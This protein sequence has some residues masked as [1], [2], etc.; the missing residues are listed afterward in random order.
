M[1][2]RRGC[3]CGCGGLLVVMIALVAAG[4]FFVYRPIINFVDGWRVPARSAQLPRPS[5]NLNAPISRSEVEQF[6]RVRR[7][8]RK[9]LGGSFSSAQSIL[10]DIQNGQT[11]SFWQFAGAMRDLGTSVGAA[12]QAQV[13]GLIGQNLSR[14][15]YNVIA[16]GV[17]RSLGVP[18][19]DF[20]KIASDIKSGR[21]PDIDTS[22]STGADPQTVKLIEPFKTELTATAALG[23]LGL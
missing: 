9:A 8:E 3:G 1:N 11:P 23:L 17:N 19:V 18:E 15:R 21:V 16:A 13:A 2:A 5:G 14:E 20:G 4:Y 7:L 6:V 12:R 10:N 22:V